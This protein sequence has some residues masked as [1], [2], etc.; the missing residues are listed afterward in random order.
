[1]PVFVDPKTCVDREHCFA[2]GACP[3]EAFIH[4]SLQKTWEVDATIC[5]D[6]PGPCLNFCDK[7]ALHWGDDLVDLQLVRAGVEGRMKPEEVAEGRMK[8]KREAAE[9]AAAE[10]AAAEAAKAKPGALVALTRQNFEQEVLRS[11]LPV[12]VDCWAAWCAPC[13]QFSPVFEATAKQYAGVVKFAK[14]D[15]EAEPALAQGL[16][17]QALPTV[18]MF[19][20]GQ[21]VNAAEG[22]LPASHF[23]GWIYQTLA[24]IRQYEQQLAAEADDAITAASQN[25]ATM[26]GGDTAP[27]PE[28]SAVAGAPPAPP[29]PGIT[30]DTHTPA[31]PPGPDAG[32]GRP[33]RGRRT[34]SG[35]YIP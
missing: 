18:L 23:Q 14:L 8:H 16:G 20:K 30:L 35:L 7:D 27:Q 10:A 13:K 25:L 26:D 34:T 17:V 33:A 15:T 11:D 3:Y 4:N 29:S 1:M 32:N 6:C 22:A 12:V 5:G 19:Y 31:P 24:A 2:A 28:Q 21:L 9:A